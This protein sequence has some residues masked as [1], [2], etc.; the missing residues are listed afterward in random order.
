MT[1][2]RKD[3]KWLDPNEVVQ[4]YSD[5]PN[6]FEIRRAAVELAIKQGWKGPEVVW[7]AQRVYAFLKGDPQ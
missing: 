1:D 5:L 4:I 6:D 7:E 2:D 3:R